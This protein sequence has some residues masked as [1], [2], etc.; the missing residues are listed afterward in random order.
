MAEPSSRMELSEAPQRQTFPQPWDPCETD[1]FDRIGGE[2]S[3]VCH[4]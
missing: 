2:L 4:A 3:C 1:L